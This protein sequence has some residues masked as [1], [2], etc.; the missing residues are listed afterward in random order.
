M[1]ELLVFLMAG[2]KEVQWGVPM[3][4]LMVESSEWTMGQMMVEW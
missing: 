1:V 4:A 3:A 2:L